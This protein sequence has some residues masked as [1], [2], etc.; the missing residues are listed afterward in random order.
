L[1][2]ILYHFSTE[3]E[4]HKQFGSKVY[5]FRVNP[6]TTWYILKY[7]IFVVELKLP[8]KIIE[9]METKKTIKTTTTKAKTTENGVVKKRISK[10]MKAAMRIQGAFDREEVLKYAHSI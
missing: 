8:T 7:I 3:Y 1:N 5:K 6:K 10:T 9:I 4:Y 2:N